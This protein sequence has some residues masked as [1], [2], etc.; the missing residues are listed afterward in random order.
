MESKMK[1]TPVKIE[2][3]LKPRNHVLLAMSKRNGAGKH[4]KSEKATRQQEKIS[5]RKQFKF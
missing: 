1:K 3:E 5:L 2:V 4:D